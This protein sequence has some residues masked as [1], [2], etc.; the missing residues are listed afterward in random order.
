MNRVEALIKLV[1]QEK[2]ADV[3]EFNAIYS[4]Y[5][6]S[7][8]VK[9]GFVIKGRIG[10]SR[11]GMGG[12][13]ILSVQMEEFKHSHCFRQNYKFDIL[14][15]ETLLLLNLRLRNRLKPA[16]TP[17]RALFQKLQIIVFLLQ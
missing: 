3:S 4:I 13:T 6:Q 7:T 17:C 14:E 10:G 9:A 11:T 15:W 5:S 12:K 16:Q 2:E 8:L 1:A